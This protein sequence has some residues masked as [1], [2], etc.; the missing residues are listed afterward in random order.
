MRPTVVD[1]S[2]AFSD[3]SLY[4]IGQVNALP[5]DRRAQIYRSLIP[6]D[7]VLRFDIDLDALT[8]ETGSPLFRVDAGKTSVELS[9]RHADDA[10]DPLL[11]LQLAD[12]ATGQIEVVM[13][14]VNDPYAERFH[15]DRLPD[16][17]PTH[18]GT[19]ARNI[20]EEIRAMKVGLAPGQVRRGLRLSRDLV[21]ILERFVEGLHHDTFYIQPLAYHNAILF[22]RLGFSYALGLGRMEWIHNEF[23]PGG[24]LRQRLDGSTP[25]R[26]PAAAGT[27]R[28]RS[29]AIHDGVM[30]T[31]YEGIKM[32]K[33]VGVHAGVIT[34]P[35]AVW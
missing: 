13:F 24:L 22:E 21:P 7:I 14:I 11:Y 23:L 19:Q 16:G 25:F 8:S 35:R 32:Y 5:R 3:L 4:S 17:T 15:I 33:R 27:V 10:P 1:P 2:Q 34:F 28:G 12:T 9:L 18:F 6:L 31:P 30:G 29:W 26:R 20:S